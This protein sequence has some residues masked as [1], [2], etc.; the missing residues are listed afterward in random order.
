MALNEQIDRPTRW[1]AAFGSTMSD[2][3]F[4]LLMD[5]PEI[6]T[7]D[8]ADFP[9]A[10]PLE[11]LVRYDMKVNRYN[12]GEI[13]VREGDYGNSAFLILEGELLIARS[14]GIPEEQLGRVSEGKKGFLPRLMSL[15]GNGSIPEKRDTDR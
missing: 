9:K 2:S 3:D 11:G 4:A 6:K 5:R 13:V 12:A 8:A 14:P 1:D 10:A 15:I 7:L